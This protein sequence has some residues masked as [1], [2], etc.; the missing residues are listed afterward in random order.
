MSRLLFTLWDGGGNVPPVLG[1]AGDL[2]SRNHEVF[3]L[4]DE[5]LGEAVSRSGARHVPWTT[6]PQRAS[7]DPATEF[8]RDFE[9]R[10]P[11]GATARIRDRLIVDPADAFARDTT[12][13]IRQ[14]GADAVIS[15]NLLMGC[16]VAATSAGLPNI[17]LVPNVYP[18]KVPGVPPFGL[19][20]AVREGFIS[21]F[22]DG[23][24][25]RLGRR[26]WDSR[27]ADVN[28]FLGNYG[29]PPLST[30]FE[31]L[32]RPD[33][34]LVLTAAAFEPGGGTRVPANVRYCGPR[35]ED[36]DWTSGWSEP[37][38]PGPLVLVSLSTTTQGQANMIRRIIGALGRLPVR[39]LVTTGPSFRPQG[40]D[41]PANVTVLDSAPHSVVMPHAG[42]VIT[43]AGH[44]T[45][46]KS[47]ANGVPLLCMPVGRDQPDTA[48]R[49][50]ACGAGLRLRPGAGTHSITRA[51]KRILTEPSFR[52]A[53]GKMSE[54][55][56]T[57]YPE[58]TAVKEIETAAKS[59]Q[60]QSD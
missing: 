38:G 3:V 15:E 14:V 36:P 4:A 51:L 34:V 60:Q 55:I 47:L 12:E 46:I 27:L 41:I 2:A 42:A 45:V 1:L 39:G 21:R 49:V 6:A 48:A 57:D 50:V 29:Q 44:G 33:R 20:L 11:F 56:A 54:A 17:S 19:G 26:L 7:S 13:A 59:R 10:T 9:P 24:A 40:L 22:R 18:G 52:N 5:S 23:A 30:L 43:H 37:E 25:S 28:R 32:E 35:L 16:Q 31:M 53:A 8:V 58:D